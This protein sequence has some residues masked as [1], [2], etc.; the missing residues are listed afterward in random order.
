M[1]KLKLVTLTYRRNV[2]K[3]FLLRSLQHLA[4]AMRRE[5][6]TFEYARFPER[7]LRGRIHLHLVVMCPFI[8]QK[9]LSQAWKVASQGSYI[10]DIRNIYTADRLA[11]YLAKDLTK[12]LI[13]RVTFSR[14]FPN[15]PDAH[16]PQP[17][18][19]DPE[20]FTYRY[21]DIPT[22]LA[23]SAGA[24]QLYTGQP[25]Y[26]NGKCDCF[27]IRSGPDPP[28]PNLTAYPHPFPLD[29]HVMS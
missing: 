5:F 19:E 14:G 6:G 3:A 15:F 21:V 18:R 17:D 29:R 10:V 25:C 2:D 11:R 1:H 9:T 23:V 26:P 7:T 16:D 20:R 27:N 22:A 4:Q 28:Q 24:P 12:G 8:P 13:G